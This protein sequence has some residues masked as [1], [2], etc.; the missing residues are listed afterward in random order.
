MVKGLLLGRGPIPRQVFL[1]EVN[2][3]VGDGGIVR[4]ESLVEVGKT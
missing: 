2:E 1:G 4:D 3:G